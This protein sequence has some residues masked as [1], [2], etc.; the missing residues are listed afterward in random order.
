MRRSRV[1]D[2][3]WDC[4]GWGC[5]ATDT[6]AERDSALTAVLFP[7]EEVEAD[8]SVVGGRGGSEER[9]DEARG[10]ENAA[11]DGDDSFLI[12][13]GGGSGERSA[14]SGFLGSERSRACALSDA[15][16]G[17]SF[18]FRFFDALALSGTSRSEGSE[19]LSS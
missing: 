1:D 13:R 6:D 4:G 17:G 2:E 3:R 15:L 12:W 18:S 11:T 5:C 9:T 10:G 16:S 14:A 7:E 19:S 8:W